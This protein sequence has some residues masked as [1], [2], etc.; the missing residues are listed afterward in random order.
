MI[1]RFY[2]LPPKSEKEHV[3][4]YILFFHL[5]TTVAPKKENQ[6]QT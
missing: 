3:N 2:K 4:E 5:N 6:Q 1:L